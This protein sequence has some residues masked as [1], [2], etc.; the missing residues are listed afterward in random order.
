MEVYEFNCHQQMQARVKRTHILVDCSTGWRCIPHLLQISTPTATCLLDEIP[1]A[2]ERPQ[3]SKRRC[4]H[5]M[6]VLFL[7]AFP[8]SCPRLI[9]AHTVIK[10]HTLTCFDQHCVL[11]LS[12]VA[13]PLT[14]HQCLAFLEDI[15]PNF[16]NVFVIVYTLSSSSSYT[17]N[18]SSGP[19]MRS[20]EFSSNI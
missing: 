8:I 13:G 4:R 15:F 2:L 19:L 7:D 20:A 17:S 12:V 16:L 9:I 1:P 11:H 5:E 14:R 18:S 6:V 10:A 3:R